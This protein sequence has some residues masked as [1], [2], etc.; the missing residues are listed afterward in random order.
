[1]CILALGDAEQAWTPFFCVDKLTI[2]IWNSD[3]N[4]RASAVMH[5][6]FLYIKFM[7]IS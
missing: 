7:L 3:I 5:I 1:M 2:S 6:C 4:L